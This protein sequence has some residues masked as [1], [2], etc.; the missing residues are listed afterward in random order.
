M[1]KLSTFDERTKSL[2]TGK[3]NLEHLYTFKDFP[4]F[5]GCV[6][7]PKDEDI[8]ADMVWDICKDTGLIQL[9]KLIPLEI[10]YKN[11]HNDG[12]GKIWGEHYK[13]FAEF[14]HTYKPKNLLEI[15]GAHDQIARNY[16]TLDP[17]INWTIV[18]PN[19]EHIEDPKIK[20]IKNWFDDKFIIDGHFDTIIHSHTF[21]HTYDPVVF[22]EHISKFMKKG[23]RHIFTF[24][25]L[26][27]MLKHNWTNCLNFEHTV[28]LTEDFTEYILKKFGF[29]ILEKKYYGDPHSIFYATEKKETSST[30]SPMENKY[31]EYKSI[32]MG[33]INYHLD[34][35]KELN[36][37]TES[38]D[39]PVYLFGAHI[40]SQTLI[41]FGLKTD[42]VVSILDNSPMKQGKRLYGTRFMIDS[43]KILKDKG[44]VNVILKAGGYN[45]EIK[46]DILENINSEVTFW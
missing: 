17:E 1:K 35:I 34:M 2:L 5:M 15:G 43:P 3:D 45:A 30:L 19:P 4:V 27:P 39:K 22:I 26:L 38:S 16:R 28:F 8:V 32:F 7:S 12:T 33:Y 9:Q 31:K 40:F 25:N 18:E 13:A 24:P 29:V 41:Q 44:S 21:E 46:K 36:T 10:L 42:K 11:Q 6:D 20:V 14:I 23:D 37:L